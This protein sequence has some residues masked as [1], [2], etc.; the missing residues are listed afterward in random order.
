METDIQTSSVHLFV[1]RMDHEF[2]YLVEY[3][4]PF[5]YFNK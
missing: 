5:G 4:Y 3:V 1:N 2:R